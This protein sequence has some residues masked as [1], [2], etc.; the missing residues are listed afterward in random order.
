MQ[1]GE[2]VQELQRI[3][4]FIRLGSIV[5]LLIHFYIACY[6]T[7]QYYGISNDYV[8]R[9]FYN[10]TR[11]LFFLATLTKQKIT[12]LLLLTISLIG[13]RGRKD[14]KLT[15][16]PIFFCI[17]SGLIL[18]FTSNI[19]LAIP[20]YTLADPLYIVTTTSGYITI[21]AGGTRLTKVLNLRYK[22]DIFN[23]KNESFPQC[24]T[25]IANEYSVNLP[26]Q[27]YLRGK[28]RK[29]IINLYCVFRG[30]II[31][32]TPGSGK[33]YYFFRHIISQHL[34]KGFT[35][36]IFDFKFPDLTKIAYNHLLKN[37]HKYKVP[38][39]F[40]IIN[41]DDLSRTHRCNAL[42]PELMHDI[43]DAT[44][45][46]RTF[47]LALNREWQRKVGDFFVESPI[48]F[49]TALFWFLRKYE[50]GKYCTL[51]HVIE[52]AQIEYQRLFPVLSLEEEISVLIN[53]FLSAL[54]HGANE[55][56]EGQVASAKI[57]M[58]RISSPSL[59]YVLSGHDFNLDVNNPN[60]PKIVCIGSNPAKAQTYGA[61]ISLYTERMFKLVNQKDKI[62]S[63]LI[64]DE[65]PTLYAP[66]IDTTIA[67]ARSNK[68]AT[69]LGIQDMSQLVK[70][71]GKESA[72][73]IMNICGNIIS[74][75]VMGDTARQVSDRIG[76]IMQERE[77]I[78]INASDTSISR[79][80]QL[81]TA[82]PPSKIAGLSSGHF[83]GVLADEPSQP[84]KLK[85]FHCE[86]LNNH[87]A[88]RI[89]ESAYVDIP[90]IRNDNDVV[91]QTYLQIKKDVLNIIDT[92]I[93]KIKSNPAFTQQDQKGSSNKKSKNKSF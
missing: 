78:S 6:T 10:L 71:Y 76:K 92:E 87:E 25:L 29:S 26:A 19:L 73:V 45:S 69:F 80:M 2:N 55:Q 28:L 44:E 62:K 53:P 7:F 24:E 30:T 66:A 84:L 86:A 8:D 38:P 42:A 57:A 22:G 35:M 48:N 1:T 59:Y 77:S 34:E 63:S 79:N 60:D 41:F 32:G 18:Y 89:E 11:S 12:I 61:V 14:D 31:L 90:I 88:I 49:T 91:M 67:T 65:F 82:V 75:Q 40:Y 5:I 56:L 15:I 23:E 9:F 93:S 51:P 58:A 27:Y 37:C 85:A 47:M 43:T 46:S 4:D 54:A 68:V 64:F 39:K 70:N 50:N 20:N 74:G 21:L 33:T 13:T 72:D 16:I 3:L 52:L 36:F 17:I 83:V 81:D